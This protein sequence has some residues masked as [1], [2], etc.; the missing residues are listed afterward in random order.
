VTQ[1]VAQPLLRGQVL[2]KHFL[3]ASILNIVLGAARRVLPM[4]VMEHQPLR[5]TI[6]ACSPPRICCRDFASSS[7]ITDD[8]RL[9]QMTDLMIEGRTLAIRILHVIS[10]APSLMIRSDGLS[11][12]LAVHPHPHRFHTVKVTDTPNLATQASHS[13]SY[14]YQSWTSDGGTSKIIGGRT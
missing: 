9:Q 11:Q 7:S 3:Y 1:L 2:A 8:G 10:V 4:M 13:G 12:R 6:P 14:Y 5:V